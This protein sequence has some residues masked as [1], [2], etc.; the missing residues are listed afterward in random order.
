MLNSS[1]ELLLSK[2]FIFFQTFGCWLILL[3][4]HS[5]LWKQNFCVPTRERKPE[6]S[7]NKEKNNKNLPLYS[8]D[9]KTSV[10]A[11]GI[12]T[13][14]M[15]YI[16][17]LVEVL[18]KTSLILVMWKR[19]PVEQHLCE[20]P[21]VSF[22]VV[23]K[24][25]HY[26]LC[27]SPIHFFLTVSVRSQP[28]HRL[29]AVGCRINPD[30]F[31]LVVNSLFLFGRSCLSYCL[32][33]ISCIYN[34]FSGVMMLGLESVRVQTVFSV[35]FSPGIFSDFSI[36]WNTSES[37]YLMRYQLTFGNYSNYFCLESNIRKVLNYCLF[38]CH[39][40]MKVNF[41]TIKWK[42]DIFYIQNVSGKYFVGFLFLYLLT[43]SLKFNGS[44]IFSN[45]QDFYR[46]SVNKSWVG[47]SALCA[48][49]FWKKLSG[50]EGCL[51]SLL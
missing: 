34:I 4:S 38:E 1:F 11:S 40:E 14:Y 44:G 43:F 10:K 26:F 31:H 13:L 42:V 35:C 8:D 33:K 30:C 47:N 45:Q 37:D 27:S 19:C 46:S 22:S 18:K 32:D 23:K 2:P 24:S 51:T 21:H 48:I 7:F 29:W 15:F 50:G 25:S 17:C 12:I 49:I 9:H 28:K 36:V 6:S 20:P 41:L 16:I 3:F 5:S 39:L